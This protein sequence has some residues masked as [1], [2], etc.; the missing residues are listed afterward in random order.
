M[1][2][3]INTASP[4]PAIVEAGGPKK[5]TGVWIVVI[6][7]TVLLLGGG[8]AAYAAMQGWIQLPYGL[9]AP[10]QPSLEDIG[11]AG[12][13]ITS[14]MITT[15]MSLQIM[16]RQEGTPVIPPF[17]ASDSTT[18]TGPG[19]P[20]SAGPLTSFLASDT[21]VTTELS[22]R[23]QAG[24]QTDAEGQLKGTYQSSGLSLNFDAAYR[25][26]DS[27]LYVQLNSFPIPILDFPAIAGTWVRLAGAGLNGASLL[28]MGESAET[29]VWELEAP[30]E[31]VSP[32]TFTEREKRVVE[33]LRVLRNAF[34]TRKALVIRSATLLTDDAGARVWRMD[35][36]MDPVATRD[37]LQAAVDGRPEGETHLF[38]TD[39]LRDLTRREGFLDWLTAVS[40]ATRST[41]DVDPKTSLPVRQ[42]FSTVF[43]LEG[44]E[45]IP[46][47]R[48]YRVDV[49]YALKDVNTPFSVT[50]PNA[51]EWREAMQQVMHQ[52]DEDVLFDEQAQVITDLRRAL[53]TYQKQKGRYPDA[54]SELIG[55]AGNVGSLTRHVVN[56]PE[57][58]YTLQPFGY[59]AL[60]EGKEYTLTYQMRIPEASAEYKKTQYVE[61]ANTATPR[62]LSME[63]AAIQDSDEDGL[64]NLEESRLGTNR[65]LDDSDRDGFTDKEEVDAGY[66]PLANPKTGK[67]YG[68]F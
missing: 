67:T 66:D 26:V 28:S 56:I 25:R 68:P 39:D 21:T 11:R 54:L 57:D 35:V 44:E 12:E 6:V 1:Q 18:G 37:A 24:T 49:S 17:P 30:S 22:T 45:D 3:M 9:L 5:R 60:S 4:A 42:T 14:G 52:T 62:W 64:S 48:Q 16:D 19:F 38:L 2:G 8:G 23:F 36:L 10:R 46:T 43:A 33:E 15:A 50:A 59:A 31:T 32:D 41:L 27:D 47:P 29:R 61:G 65:S 63:A 20:L 58:R 51:I 7:V 40:N 53:E 34:F 55:V 13:G